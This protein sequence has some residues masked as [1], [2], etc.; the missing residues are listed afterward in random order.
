L[1][2]ILKGHRLFWFGSSFSANVAFSI[3]GG[4]NSVAAVKQIGIEDKVTTFQQE[5]ERC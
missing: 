5:E 1:K 3:V 2:Y 4:G